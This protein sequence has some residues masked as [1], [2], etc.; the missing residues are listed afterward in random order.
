ML[1]LATVFLTTCQT[2]FS[3]MPSPMA[4][5][6]DRHIG[7]EDR[8]RCRLQ[9]TTHQA[10]LS[11]NSGRERFECPF[12][13]DP[14][15][16]RL[17]RRIVDER[18]NLS[19][20]YSVAMTKL[21]AAILEDGLKQSEYK[22]DDVSAAAEVVR[23]AVTVFVHPVHVEAASKAGISMEHAILRMMATQ[24]VDLHSGV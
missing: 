17:Y 4:F 18:P 3:E 19:R 16:Y 8:S 7:R 2:V 23:D 22:V 21:I 15:V 13:N 20:N 9:S 24:N 6:P 5:P 12:A 14:E 11:A 1:M 10:C